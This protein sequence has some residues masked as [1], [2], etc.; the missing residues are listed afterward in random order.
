MWSQIC[1]NEAH[2]S[3]T[4]LKKKVQKL[5]KKDFFSIFFSLTFWPVTLNLAYFASLNCGGQI[6]P[7]NCNYQRCLETLTWSFFGWQGESL[8]RDI[9]FFILFS[10]FYFFLV[11][12]NSAYYALL[13]RVGFFQR[14]L[15]NSN[16]INFGL[17]NWVP[18]WGQIFLL[19]HFFA[20][21]FELSLLCTLK[22][23]VPDFS[24][25]FNYQRCPENSNMINFWLTSWVTS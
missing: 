8:C 23:C 1:Q 20:G 4:L 7:V 3:I 16:I 12:W 13:V 9:F 15:E 24:V 22:W 14:F 17:T 6:F 5:K 19:F 11:T 18:L 21:H 2:L 25:N 10:P